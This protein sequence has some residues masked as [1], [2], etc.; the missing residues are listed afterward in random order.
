MLLSPLLPPN[1]HYTPS[2]LDQSDQNFLQLSQELERKSYEISMF[3]KKVLQPRLVAY[4][5]DEWVDYAYSQT[6]LYG[7]G[8]HPLLD[9]VRQAIIH[10]YPQA[11]SLNSV[12]CNLYRDGSDSMGRHADD[13]SELWDDP[14]IYSVTL[15]S[16]RV[17]QIKSKGWKSQDSWQRY[18][19]MLEDNSLLMMGSG[20]QIDY[21]H[22]IPKT[23][24]I[25][26]PRINLTFRTIF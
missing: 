5:A 21:V 10:L 19:L 3:G 7:H 6:K 26:W 22:S 8:W 14:H 13:E 4:C 20:S 2:F 25:I 18:S 9:Q 1:F 23:K 15:G 12:L 17:F 16:E 11:N 24:K